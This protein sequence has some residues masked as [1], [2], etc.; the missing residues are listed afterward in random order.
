M[1]INSTDS[2]FSSIGVVRRDKKILSFPVTFQDFLGSAGREI[3]LS[4]INFT[5]HTGI[6]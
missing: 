1:F 4:R 3:I 5:C 6:T 2:I